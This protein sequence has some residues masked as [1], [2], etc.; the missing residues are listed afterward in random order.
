MDSQV[1]VAI[2]SGGHSPMP[3]N[4][5]ID[6]CVLISLGNLDSVSYDARSELASYRVE[7]TECKYYGIVESDHCLTRSKLYRTQVQSSIYRK[8]P[9]GGGLFRSTFYTITK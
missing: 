6:N 9:T 1:P 4:A 2:R 8:E 5:N 3:L 7:L